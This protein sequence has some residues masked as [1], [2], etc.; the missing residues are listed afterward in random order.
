M[1]LISMRPRRR[2]LHH[3]LPGRLLLGG[4][5]PLHDGDHRGLRTRGD[6]GHSHHSAQGHSV[7]DN[8]NNNNNSKKN[9]DK[10]D[11]DENLYNY[12]KKYKKTISCYNFL[13]NIT[14][15]LCGI[16]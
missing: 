2:L 10:D 11:H 16:V 6:A 1:N 9:T 12:D 13:L 3:C 7:G 15:F 5:H 8:N 4:R 14:P